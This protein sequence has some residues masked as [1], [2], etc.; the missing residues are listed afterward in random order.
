MYK[1]TLSFEKMEYILDQKD[2]R[3]V[4]ITNGV[5]T[6]L[7]MQGIEIAEV[8][9]EDEIINFALMLRKAIARDVILEHI[10]LVHD[11][12]REFVTSDEDS[13]LYNYAFSAPNLDIGSTFL[14][15]FN[16][17][18][19]ETYKMSSKSPL[20]RG[21]RFSTYPNPKYRTVKFE[22]ASPKMNVTFEYVNSEFTI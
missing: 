13:V 7:I 9:K 18:P 2:L 8:T 10:G 1:I 21:I 12:L 3:S 14:I 16:K 11:R 22:G 4:H 19:T 6:K 20:L 17:L 5:G 15:I